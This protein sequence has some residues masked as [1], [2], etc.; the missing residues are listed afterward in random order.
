M[1]VNSVTLVGY[2]GRTPEERVT[3]SGKTLCKMSLA[4]QR[5][6]KDKGEKVADWHNVI[7]WEKQAEKCLKYLDKGS[8]IAVEGRIQTSKL[9]GKDG[10]PKYWTQVVAWRVTFLGGGRGRDGRPGARSAGTMSG[11]AVVSGTSHPI[12]DDIPF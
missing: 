2:L 4:T 9:D 3:Q 1:S 7:A 6:D 11:P 12:D 8:Q 10:K 5:W